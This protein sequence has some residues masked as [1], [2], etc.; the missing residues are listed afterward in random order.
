MSLWTSSAEGAPRPYH[1][2]LMELTRTEIQRAVW[3]CWFSQ[4][5]SLQPKAQNLIH[6]PAVLPMRY[7]FEAVRT[8]R[9]PFAMAGVASVNSPSEFFP[10]TLNAG[11]A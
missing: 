6:R 8:M 1:R 9:L 11:P 10:S 3:C 5:Q 7:S 2:M 4:A